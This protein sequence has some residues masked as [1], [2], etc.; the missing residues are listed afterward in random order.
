MNT[1]RELIKGES[2]MN[3][4]ELNQTEW[5]KTFDDESE[6]IQF[7]VPSDWLWKMLKGWAESD[8]EDVENDKK[9]Y[10]EGRTEHLYEHLEDENFA[11]SIY[12]LACE[13]KVIISTKK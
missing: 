8:A 5:I 6:E 3:K 12:D 4:N 13:N 7:E 11:N 10:I 1:I 9:T 2:R